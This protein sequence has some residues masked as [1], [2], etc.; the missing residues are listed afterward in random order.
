MNYLQSAW[1]LLL[2]SCLALGVADG[3]SAPAPIVPRERLLMDFGWKFHLGNDWGPGHYLAKA[4]SGFGPAGTVFSDASWRTVNLPHDWAVELPFDEKADISHGFKPVGPGYVENSVGWYRRTF[5][6][7]RADASRRIVLEFDGVYR[8]C[9]VFVNGWCLARNAS[10]YSPFRCDITDVANFGGKNVVA[11]RVDASE[12]E[13]WFY[14]GAGIYR[15]VWL[16]KTGG[17]AIVPD[18]VF[19]QGSFRN[20]VPGGPA[21]VEVQTELNCLLPGPA[22]EIAVL[23]ELYAPDGQL[24]AR[25]REPVRSEESSDLLVKYDVRV[26]APVLWSP[27]TP[28]LYK[29]VSTVVLGQQTV[30]RQETAFGLR[31]VAF[32]AQRGFLLNGQPYVIKGTCNHQDHAGVGAALPDRLQYFRV[33]KL[34]EMGCNAYRTSHNPPTPE[35]LDACDRLGLLVMDENR[36]LGSSPDN[37]ELL[38][39]LIRRDR[40]HPSVFLWSIANEEFSVQGTPAGRRAAAA[41]QTAIRKLDTTRPITY[42]APVGNEYAGVNEVIE[43]RGWNYHIGPDDDAYHKAHPK[44]PNVGT[45]QGSTVSTRGVYVADPARGYVTAYDVNYPPWANTAEQWWS[46]YAAR[47]WLSGGFVWTGFDYRGEPTPSAWPCI[48]S[49]FGILD[50]CGFPK[51]NFWYYRA[52][53]QEKPVLHLLPHWNWQGREG[54]EI[55]VRAL[56]NCD[57]V[58]LFL[59]GASLGRKAMPRN[60]QLSWKVNYTPGVLS[61]K[62]FCGGQVVLE[63]K[64]E[65]TGAPAGVRLV[66]DRSEIA[67]DGEDVAVYTVEIVDAQ[68]RVVPTAGDL[69]RFELQ[70]PGRLLGVGNGDPSCHEPD[71]FVPVASSRSLAISSW[72]MKP[73][74]GD[75]PD[76][77]PELAENHVDAAWAEVSLDAENGSLESNRKAVYRGHVTLSA[78]DL[79]Q[80]VVELKIGKIDGNGA[81][82]VNGQKVGQPSNPKVAAIFDVRKLLHAGDNV[83]ALSVENYNSFAAGPAGHVSLEVQAAPVQPAWSRPVFNGLAQIIVQASKEA[84]ELRL[85]AAASGLQ[86]AES[87]VRTKAAVAR[88]CVP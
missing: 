60:S 24:L 76:S 54:Q 15:H 59:N 30:D 63:E 80:P 33:A 32:D 51:D 82:Y 62:G 8:N 67:A 64:V 49:H 44:Q 18:G 13:G 48:S 35:L 61:A 3:A 28:R 84:G 42:A 57:E 73:V 9:T 75:L 79:A 20:N 36:L 11:V 6:L 46:F 85:S 72:R 31:T 41:M 81:V 7:S 37:L 25:G 66:P 1:A 27:E 14:E 21:M 16:V 50:T 69:V 10:G 47:P 88:P 77:M 29:L 19:V 45:E 4:G 70:G 56:S 12:P 83:V 55:E 38:G 43:V 52:W 58:E 74:E 2:F 40:N 86:G 34:K 78:E 22:E 65:T 71:T 87:V 39:R 5:S 26:D 17:V 23:W 53:W 68:G